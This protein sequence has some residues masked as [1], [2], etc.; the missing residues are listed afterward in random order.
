M[1][2]IGAQIT[3][4]CNV[5]QKVSEKQGKICPWPLRTGNKHEIHPRIFSVFGHPITPGPNNMVCNVGSRR[6]RN[7]RPDLDPI[8]N[9]NK[10]FESGSEINL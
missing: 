4:H 8:R 2:I 10:R 1:H 6:I 5:L 3:L 9:R 7:F